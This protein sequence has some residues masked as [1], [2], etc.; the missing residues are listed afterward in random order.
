MCVTGVVLTIAWLGLVSAS[1]VDAG[2]PLTVVVHDDAGVSSNTLDRARQL[3][4]SVFND[5]GVHIAWMNPAEFVRS[6]PSEADQ[7]RA[8]VTSIVQIRFMSPSMTRAM[9]LPDKSL[10]IAVASARFAWIAFDKIRDS[11]GLVNLDPGDALGYVMAHELGHLLLPPN[12]HSAAGLMREELDPGLIAHN[13]VRF[14]DT[15]AVR[16][17]ASLEEHFNSPVTWSR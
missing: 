2:I 7:K 3:V 17:R 15:D 6:L 5:V 4:S 16:I 1:G 14:L 8:F 12:S 10:G 11:A 13:R 9:G